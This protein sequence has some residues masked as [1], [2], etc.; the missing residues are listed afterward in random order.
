MRGRVTVS[1]WKLHSEQ[2]LGR[3]KCVCVCV[4]CVRPT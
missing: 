3:I 2:E 1:R 4:L